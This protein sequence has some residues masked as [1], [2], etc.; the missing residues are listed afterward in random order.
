MEQKIEFSIAKSGFRLA[1]R[2]A[3]LV[4]GKFH[5]YCKKDKTQLLFISRN[6]VFDKGHVYKRS[7]NG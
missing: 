4:E 3:T 1:K 6:A 7:E 5:S 2:N